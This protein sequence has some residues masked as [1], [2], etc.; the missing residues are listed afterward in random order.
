MHTNIALS[1]HLKKATKCSFVS[2]LA[3]G[4]LKDKVHQK[5][6]TKFFSSYHIIQH[7]GEVVYNLALLAQ[8]KIHLVIH[9]SCLKKVV[10]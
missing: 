10:G 5:F 3:S 8:P 2:N 7:I 9:V 1:V 4:H 6:T